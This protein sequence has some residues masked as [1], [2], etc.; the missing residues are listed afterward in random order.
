MLITQESLSR[1]VINYKLLNSLP[2]L[3]HTYDR[4][5]EYMVPVIRSDS[6]GENLIKLESFCEYSDS[7]S[8]DD[9]GYAISTICEINNISPR[10]V[11]FYVEE[12]N[13]YTNDIL[14]ETADILKEH[15]YH[16]YM[17]PISSSSFYYQALQ[18]AFL[19]DQNYELEDSENLI[20]YCED[21]NIFDRARDKIGHGKDWLVSGA[22]SGYRKVRDGLSDAKDWAGSGLD[23]TAKKLASAKRTA[24]E[25]AAKASRAAGST[26]AFLLRQLDKA[27]EIVRYLENKLAKAKVGQKVDSAANTFKRGASYVGKK[28]GSGV[29]YVKDTGRRAYS[30]IKGKFS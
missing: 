3:E 22:K 25:L 17:S 2:I 14:L 5:S 15:G 9:A 20:A 1:P 4:Y 27:K 6:T 30:G 21:G 12:T 7:N 23:S 13:C 24:K 28:V 16:V 29:D 18:E 11:G 26:K 19:M 10:A 8:I